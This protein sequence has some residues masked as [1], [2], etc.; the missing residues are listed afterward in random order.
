M[1]QA[2]FAFLAVTRKPKAAPVMVMRQLLT[3]QDAINYDVLK[4]GLKQYYIADC[5]GVS[6]S[7]VSK[8]CKGKPF[9]NNRLTRFCEV[10]GS[11][12]LQQFRERAEQALAESHTETPAQKATRLLH[13]E[14]A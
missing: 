7:L 2:N 11:T 14:A 3:E 8:W 10:T 13:M 4:S 9:P 1:N 6:E 12:A 5:M